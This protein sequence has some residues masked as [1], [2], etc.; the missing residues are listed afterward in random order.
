[1]YILYSTFRGMSIAFFIFLLY[2]EHT[3][4]KEW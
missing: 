3:V 2:N 1:M 4:H